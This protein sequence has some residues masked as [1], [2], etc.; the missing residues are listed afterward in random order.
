LPA[1]EIEANDLRCTH[2]ATISQVDESQVYYLMSRG[3]P[4]LESVRL[5]LEGFFEP[6]LDRLPESLQGLRLRLSDAIAAKL[7]G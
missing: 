6:S 7:R 4:R 1:L 5:L 2:G 3:I